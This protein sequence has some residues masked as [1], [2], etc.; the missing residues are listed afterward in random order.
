MWKDEEAALRWTSGLGNPRSSRPHDRAPPAHRAGRR[1]ST[2]RG[3]CLRAT[4]GPR[5]HLREGRAEE[6]P[7][8]TRSSWHPAHGRTRR[9]ARQSPRPSCSLASGVDTGR[10]QQAGRAAHSPPRAP[11]RPS[12]RG[13]TLA[14]LADPACAV[15]SPILAQRPWSRELAWGP[16]QGP[17]SDGEARPTA[18]R[19]AFR[20]S[21]GQD[22]SLGGLRGGLCLTGRG[23]DGCHRRRSHDRTARRGSRRRRRRVLRPVWEAVLP[24]GPRPLC[25]HGGQV[26]AVG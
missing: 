18:G 8:R 24:A 16:G 7:P 23:G 3:A 17:C 22:P 11:A 19:W 14:A 6:P 4:L 1:L 13:G 26:H 12:G 15:P 25:S 5:I 10:V 9:N 21:P 2:G 20:G